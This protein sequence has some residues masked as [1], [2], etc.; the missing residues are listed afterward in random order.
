MTPNA[1]SLADRFALPC[2]APDLVGQIVRCKA[3]VS[4]DLAGSPVEVERNGL[5]RIEWVAGGAGA[6]LLRG[7]YRPAD[8]RKDAATL[9]RS[10]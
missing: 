7:P 8:L 1:E 5:Y 3:G 4:Y 10:S 6:W 9:A 2:P